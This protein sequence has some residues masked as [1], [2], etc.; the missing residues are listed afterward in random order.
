MIAEIYKE[1]VILWQKG[2]R[3]Y[4]AWLPGKVT[5]I[6]TNQSGEWEIAISDHS[7]EKLPSI[8]FVTAIR[9]GTNESQV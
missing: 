4:T 6:T 3:R 8:V 7:Y 5:Y 2:A 1:Y 9:K